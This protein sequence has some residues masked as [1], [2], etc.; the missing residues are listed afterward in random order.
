MEVGVGVVGDGGVGMGVVVELVGVV[1][2]EDEVVGG[3]DAFGVEEVG[4]GV[5]GWDR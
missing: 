4:D 3:E 1:V 5:S 2:G